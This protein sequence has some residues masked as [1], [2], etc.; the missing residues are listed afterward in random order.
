[1]NPVMA[2]AAKSKLASLT[3]SA[4]SLKASN[5][6]YPFRVVKTELFWY[7]LFPLPSR[8]DPQKLL[9]MALFLH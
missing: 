6:F 7:R 4:I 3:V 5:I 1:M 2:L 9:V 8:R